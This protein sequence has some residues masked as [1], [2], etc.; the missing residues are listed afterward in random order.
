MSSLNI[1]LYKVISFIYT[2][3]ISMNCLHLCL[4]NSI[5]DEIQIIMKAPLKITCILTHTFQQL[6]GWLLFYLAS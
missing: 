6:M 2:H 3:T 4:F 5:H 1:Y